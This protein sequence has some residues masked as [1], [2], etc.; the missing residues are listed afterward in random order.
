VRHLDTDAVVS[1]CSTCG[2]QI[3]WARTETGKRMPLDANPS[4]DG[5]L[6]LTTD[7]LLP[8]ARSIAHG[9]RPG[10]LLFKSHFATCKHATLHRTKPVKKR[11]PPPG[12]V[13]F[14]GGDDS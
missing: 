5:N 11:L 12:D 6:T 1:T 13:L 9:H 2:G 10:Q 3:I 4:S 14:E 8:T 7:G